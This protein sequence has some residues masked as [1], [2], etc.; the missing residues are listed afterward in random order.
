M[1]SQS[2]AAEPEPV[3]SVPKNVYNLKE[4]LHER[5]GADNF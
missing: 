4:L 3:G 2:Q 1:D 5:G